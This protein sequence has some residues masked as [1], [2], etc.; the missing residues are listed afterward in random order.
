MTNITGVK[1]TINPK[2]N[3]KHIQNTRQIFVSDKYNKK[4]GINIC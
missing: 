3:K 1:S 2:C 4:Y